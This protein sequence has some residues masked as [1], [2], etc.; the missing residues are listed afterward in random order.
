MQHRFAQRVEEE[1]TRRGW[2]DASLA[3]RISEHRDDCVEGCHHYPMSASTVWKIKNS[4]PPRRVDLDEANAIAR[5]AFG[6]DSIEEFLDDSPL[7]VLRMISRDL[8]EDVT[9]VTV[10]VE[11]IES[12][13]TDLEKELTVEGVPAG[14]GAIAADLAWMGAAL[15]TIRMFQRLQSSSSRL[16]SAAQRLEEAGDAQEQHQQAPQRQA[17]HPLL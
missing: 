2:S 8:V 17:P 10:L 1:A 16:K 5:G 13:L 12:Q 6:Y 3:Q 7:L 14:A 4:D 9:L 11:R 15:T